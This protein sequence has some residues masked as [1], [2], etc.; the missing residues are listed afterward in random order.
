[1][2]RLDQLLLAAEQGALR[3]DATSSD[4]LDLVREVRADRARMYRRA[5]RARLAWH[6][7]CR[8][9]ADETNDYDGKARHADAMVRISRILRGE[10]AFGGRS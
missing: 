3:A 5:C 7:E 6:D 1:M 4:L 8:N 9:W 10:P 2:T